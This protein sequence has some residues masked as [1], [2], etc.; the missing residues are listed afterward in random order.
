MYKIIVICDKDS[1][2]EIHLFN[3]SLAQMTYLALIERFSNSLFDWELM[4]ISNENKIIERCKIK[5][6]KVY[7]MEE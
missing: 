2:E 3:P 5:D 4:L 7:K 6:R 1:I